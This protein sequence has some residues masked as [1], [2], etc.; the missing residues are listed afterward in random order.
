MRYIIVV[1]GLLTNVYFAFGQNLT[2]Y[3]S[4][5]TVDETTE[6]IVS[7]IKEEGL[8]FFEIV[9]HDQIAKERGD[10]LAP[11]KSILFEDPK[12]TTQL[13][14]CQQTTAL[15]LP[16]EILVW[17]EFGDV[18]IGFV[19]PKFMKKRFMIIGCDETLLEL[20]RLMLRITNNSLKED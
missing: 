13:I 2:I 19:D 1:L 12:L 7:L 9:S 3:K 8:I 14:K 16:L 5:R 6:K 20:T 17:D 18:Y 15:D 4:D 10:T 11:T